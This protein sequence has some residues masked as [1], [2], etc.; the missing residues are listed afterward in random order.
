MKKNEIK[1]LTVSQLHEQLGAERDQLQKLQFAH[2]VS[3]IENPMRLREAKKQ[4]ARLL[5]EITI[6]SNQQAA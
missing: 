4:I 6:K 1:S 3:P 2:A 5:T